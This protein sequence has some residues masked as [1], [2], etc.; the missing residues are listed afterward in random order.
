M[1]V[2]PSAVLDD[3]RFEVVVLGDLSLGEKLMLT[4]RIYK[5]THIGTPGVIAD[6]ARHVRAESREEVLLDVD[7]EPIGR[8]P[9]S[10]D[11][12]PGAIRLQSPAR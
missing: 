4:T 12:L 3:G 8:L 10:F 1:H 2:A 11:L 9:A 6:V 5:G 7:G